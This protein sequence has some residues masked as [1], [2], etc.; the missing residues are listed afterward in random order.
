M[1]S[2]PLNKLLSKKKQT[3]KNL[4]KD[5]KL[6]S[7]KPL[8]AIF[9]DNELSKK[10]EEMIDMF[11]S[12]ISSIDL[13]VV[14]LADSNLK[15]FKSPMITVLPY[16]RHNRQILLEAADMAL[17]FSFSDIEEMLLNGVIPISPKRNEIVDYNPNREVGNA[18]IYT[19]EDP[20]AIFAALVRAR[21]TYKFPYDWKHLIRE[22]VESV[23]S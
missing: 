10:Q 1:T 12:G 18:F 22:G 21:E 14:V 6:S 13:Q 23:K 20:W 8:L 15:S 5:L 17:S 11:L 19:K 3:K 16:S 7:K 2:L 9:V 4:S